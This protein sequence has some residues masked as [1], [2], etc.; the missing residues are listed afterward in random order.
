MQKTLSSSLLTLS[1][2]NMEMVVLETEPEVLIEKISNKG[3][4]DTSA[5]PGL[6]WCVGLKWFGCVAVSFGLLCILQVILNISLRPPLNYEARTKNLTDERDELKGKLNDFVS[7][8]DAK[9]KTMNGDRDELKRSLD[10]LKSQQNALIRERDELKR[11]LNDFDQLLQEGWVY[12]RS[13]FYYISSTEKTWQESRD[14]CLSRG[15]DLMI[16]D[17]QEEQDFSRRLSKKMWFGLTDRTQDGTWRWVDGSPLNTSY[18][19]PGEPNNLGEME[20]CA[21][22]HSSAEGNNWNDLLCDSQNHWICEK[23]VAP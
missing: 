10:D 11:T 2:N 17:S 5:A 19:F 18:W 9:I 22:I 12:F 1:L 7:G 16:I 13:S 21:E 15:A 8:H 23:K 3:N 4:R 20:D 14:D 6:K